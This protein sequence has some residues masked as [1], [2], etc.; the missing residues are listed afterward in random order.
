MRFLYANTA[1]IYPQDRHLIDGLRELGHEVVEASDM[2]SIRREAPACDAVFVGFTSPLFVMK[3]RRAAPGK[4]VFFNAVTS[5]YEANIVSRGEVGHFFLKAI[6]WWLVDA[7]SF[8]LS[9]KVLLESDAQI[10]YSSRLFLVPRRKLVKAYS[11]LNE[12]EFFYDPSVAKASQFT[13]LFRGRFLPESGILTVI[14]A[15]KKLEDAGVKFLIIGHGLLYREFN[16]LMARLAPKNV[17]HIHDKMPVDELRRRMLGCHV[18]LGQMADH[19]R[20]KRTLPCKLF[21]SLALRLPYLTGRNPAVF[22]MLEEGRTCLAAK[23]GDADDLAAQIL[24]LRDNPEVRERIAAAGYELYK[25]RLT[26]K[27]LAQEALDGCLGTR[28]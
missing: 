5:Q 13:V 6:K 12:K 26:S 3:V 25:A 27:A 17:E 4:K 21:E 19:P 14:E 7:L 15:A 18:S 10:R 22:E 23:P 20:L 2:E 11:G 8:H 28:R 24:Y 9:D 1:N 16:A